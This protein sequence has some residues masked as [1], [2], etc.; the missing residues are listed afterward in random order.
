MT[1]IS[2][3]ASIFEIYP[4]YCIFPKDRKDLI[5][6]VRN[7]LVKNRHF[8]MR[9]GGTSISG[10]AIGDGV[11]VDISKN[12]NKIISFSE[13]RREVVV[14][15]GVIQGDLNNYLKSYGLKFAP[16]TS[17]SNR[18][19]IGGMI[20]NNSCGSYSVY[21]GTTREH[22][23]SIEVLLSDGSLVIFEELNNKQLKRKLK[24]NTLEGSIYRFAVNVLY[25]K[26]QEILQAYP[27][28]GLIRRN[29][30]Y[31]IDE[32]V[33]KYRP[34]D[35]NYNSFSLVPII[36][37]SEGTLGVIIKAKLN[38]VEIPKY[39]L[40]IIAQFDSEK[41][42]LSIVESLMQFKPAA[43]EFIDKPTLDASKNNIK[44]NINRSWIRGDPKAVLVVEF[45]V[46]SKD[47]LE[48]KRS[49]VK[50]WLESMNSTECFT[51]KQKDYNKVWEIRKSGLGLLM[52]DAGPKKALA[53]IEDAAVPLKYLYKYYQE[54]KE[55]MNAYEIS[56]VY[57]GHVSVGLI[58]I[59]PKLD[60]SVDKD[61]KIM[62]ELAEKISSLVK[63]YKGSLSGEHGD[64]R[65]RSPYIKEQVGSQIYQLLVD[66]K[67]VFDPGNLLNPGVVIS[68]HSIVDNLRQVS[69]ENSNLDTGFDWSDDI[70]FFSAAEKCNGAGVCRKSPENGMMC[71]S[72][73]VSRDENLSTRG[74]ANLLRRA[75]GS[76]KPLDELRR[77]DIKAALSLCLGCKACKAECPSSVDMAKLKSE[78][79]YQTQVLRNK[80]Y[81]WHIKNLGKI[82]KIGCKLPSIFN[83]VQN[84]K[85]V[86]KIMSYEDKLPEIEGKTL[87]EWWKFN[88]S[89]RVES[90]ITIWVLCDIYTEYYD[91]QSGKDLLKILQ[92]CDVKIKLINLDLSIAALV[93]K[94]LLSDAK[95]SINDYYYKLNNISNQDL[96]VGIDPSEVLIWRDEAKSLTGKELNVLLIEEL[97]LELE[98]LSL[99]P[100][101]QSNNKTIL[102]HIHCHQQSLVGDQITMEAL[103][104][105]K[106]LEVKFMKKGC[107]GM[108]GDFGYLN[109]DFSKKVFNKLIDKNYKNMGNDAMVVS[110]GYGCR[111]QFFR[112]GKTTTTSI[113]TVFKNC[114][115]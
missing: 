78:Y 34:F 18:A 45:F 38:L 30:G 52:G 41:S 53:V 47:N 65:L 69:P 46:K 60:L 14:E 66:L 26:K 40:L 72:Y 49:K 80:F 106:G 61:K 54:V 25:K 4:E 74:R 15:P 59:R 33:K 36:C 10:Q 68:N 70:S 28:K 64:G 104:L 84:S 37:G 27:D 43:V 115:Q 94:G 82:M 13:D 35:E 39:K 58:H 22:V 16:D 76:K 110:T 3:D 9:A 56:A 107:C 32:L 57:Y 109:K 102:M 12:L 19:M 99:L 111:Q 71:P 81:G 11:L 89:V 105:I 88:K 73:H 83:F 112:F 113:S 108:A 48:I 96:I 67:K 1:L 79:L 23:K 24:L 42:A 6:V 75:L 7:L 8:T 55:L 85:Y 103:N 17:T 44:Q 63:R 114:M 20:G 31:A 50:H 100:V 87:S 62:L 77:Y 101:F 86:Q 98:N 2:T 29:T 97:F 95:K 21:Y 92:S 93:S 90:K 5:K 51:I 91:T